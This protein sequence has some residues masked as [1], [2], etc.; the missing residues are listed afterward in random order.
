MNAITISIIGLKD[1][2]LVSLIKIAIK[3]KQRMMRKIGFI[4]EI[5]FGVAPGG[6]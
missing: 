5:W 2:K 1:Y 6:M 3:T 4:H